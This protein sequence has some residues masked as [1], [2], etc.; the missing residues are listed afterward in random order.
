MTFFKTYCRDDLP[1]EY[2]DFGNIC[3]LF[4]ALLGFTVILPQIHYTWTMRSVERLHVLWPTFALTCYLV[5]TFWT[6]E[7]DDR[8]FFK[9][10]AIYYPVI[11]A[12]FLAEFWVFSKRNAMLKLSFLAGCGI[13]WASII[14]IEV[15]VSRRDSVLKM[16]W[17]STVFSSI[18]I[19]PQ[20]SLLHAVSF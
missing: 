19:L 2:C 11:Y 13:I 15:A 16:V 5:D 18:K 4:H 9:V 17:I 10:T 20:V 1:I 12:L 8:S 6:F 14:T 7:M 3:S